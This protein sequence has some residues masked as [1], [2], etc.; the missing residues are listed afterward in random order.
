MAGVVPVSRHLVRRALPFVGNRLRDRLVLGLGVGLG[1]LG[2]RLASP[3]GQPMTTT[4]T[5]PTAAPSTTG[6]ISTAGGGER[7]GGFNR[8][9]AAARPFNGD[10]RAARGYAEPR[11]QSG[12]RS[13]AFSGYGHGGEE[14]G[15]SSRGSSSFG[16]GGFGRGGGGFGQWRRIRRRT[17]R[18]WPSIG[19]RLRC[20][21]RNSENCIG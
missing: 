14:R 5:T 7:G 8:S 18:R 17:W 1:S 21:K 12:V 13:G 4:G 16:G 19:G 9:G 11:G 10:T 20:G 6:T 15:F 3:T 2:I